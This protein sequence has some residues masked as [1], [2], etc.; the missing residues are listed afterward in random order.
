MKCKAC[1]ARMGTTPAIPIPGGDGAPMLYVKLQ[2][3]SVIR[4]ERPY[5]RRACVCPDC[6]KTALDAAIVKRDKERRRRKKGA[7]S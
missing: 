6:M 5:T 1:G 3:W 2:D 4:Y 7:S